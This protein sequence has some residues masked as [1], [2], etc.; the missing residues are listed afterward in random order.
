MPRFSVVIPTLRRADT[1][2]HALA[3]VLAQPFAD[4]EVVVQNNGGDAATRDVVERAGDDRVRHFQTDDVVPMTDNWEL[5]L[6]NSAGEYVTFIGD[7]DG[8]LPDACDIAA[9]VLESGGSRFELLMWEP[10][11][12]C[13]PEFYD[14]PRRNVLLASVA[15]ELSVQPLDTHLLLERFYAFD[16]H[17]SKLPMAYNSFVA[18]TLI[19][20]VRADRGRYFL[21]TSPDVT[22]GIVNAWASKDVLKLSRPLSVAG[23]SQHSSGHRM[24][25]VDEAPP[26][27]VL[28]RDFP[29][30]ASPRS[31]DALVNL[32]LGIA[33]DMLLLQEM[34][35]AG[36]ETI[37]FSRQGLVQTLA[38]TINDNPLRYDATKEAIDRL[39]E[40][41]A[42]DPRLIV[43][44]PK[45]ARTPLPAFGTHAR[46]PDEVLHVIDGSAAGLGTIEDACGLAAQLLPADR[47]IVWKQSRSGP[48]L[49]TT[50]P[51]SFA[52]DGDGSDALATGWGEQES[53][54]TWSVQ[55][56]GVLRLRVP[57]RAVEG[58]V[59]LALR[60]RTLPLA[61]VARRVECIS[62]GRTLHAWN[63]SKSNASGEVVVEVPSHLG[64]GLLELSLHAVDARA[65][66]EL[67]LGSDTRR[68]GIGVEQIR[69]LPA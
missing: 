68:L 27:D 16:L 39:A 33:A 56:V 43:I 51:L 50:A 42:I 47:G 66:S 31:E 19:D 44:P 8:L 6:A 5:A 41:H 24:T 21:G 11:L 65:P 15:A 32:E 36:D 63:F 10:F 59:R 1:L 12:Y 54:G 23:L 26:R 37:V 14:P 67:G 28:E 22:S 40:R 45:G 34:L 35:F 62:G 53:W 2:E 4:V 20:R 61:G 57:E 46:S 58:P 49:V 38:A 29:L 17:Y 48:P 7:D 64:N 60:Y 30:L 25:M 13:W 3:T 69:L 18:R 52:R 55:P 9:T